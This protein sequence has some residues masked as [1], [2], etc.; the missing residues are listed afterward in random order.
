MFRRALAERFAHCP[1]T[2][3]ARSRYQ[4]RTRAQLAKL[5]QQMDSMVESRGGLPMRLD[6]MSMTCHEQQATDDYK[7]F[8]GRLSQYAQGDLSADAVI[9]APCDAAEIMP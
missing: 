6:G 4:Q 9:A 5:R 2:P 1:F 3:A 8:R 7:S